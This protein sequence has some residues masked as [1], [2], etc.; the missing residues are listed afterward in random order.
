MGK[1]SRAIVLS[2]LEI[3]R[4]VKEEMMC[5]WPSLAERTPT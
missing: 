3:D 1:A 4:T 5:M 2:A